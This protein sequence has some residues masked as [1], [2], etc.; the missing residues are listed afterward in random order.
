MNHALK[1][2]GPRGLNDPK[3]KNRIA[4]VNMLIKAQGK[5]TESIYNLVEFNE[6]LASI[7]IEIDPKVEEKLVSLIIP[8]ILTDYNQTREFIRNVS[9]ATEIS[10]NGLLKFFCRIGLS[11]MIS[12][13]EA[14]K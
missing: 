9:K 4:A 11:S 13:T 6:L 2:I 1:I 7:D 14:G 12:N 3:E 10:R 8:K 5:L